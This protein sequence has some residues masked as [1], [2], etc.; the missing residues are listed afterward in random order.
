MTPAIFT[1]GD[2]VVAFASSTARS[3]KSF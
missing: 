3:A 2:A 1:T